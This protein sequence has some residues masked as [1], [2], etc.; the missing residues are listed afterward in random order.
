[1]LKNSPRSCIW[2]L[3][4]IAVFF[5]QRKIEVGEFG[6]EEDSATSVAEGS[7]SRLRKRSDI[8]P[9]IH[10]LNRRIDAYS[11]HD[12]RTLIE[13]IAIAGLAERDV[14]RACDARTKLSE[15]CD[16]PTADQFVREAACAGKEPLP[17]PERQI[18]KYVEGGGVTSV[19]RTVASFRFVIVV[20]LRAAIEQALIVGIDGKVKQARSQGREAWYCIMDGQDTARVL[21]AYGEL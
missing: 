1:M 20:V 17:I 19:T 10:R 12:V 8:Q 13:V 11:R 5:D 18:V 3:S 7:G 16:F 2:S 6:P 15:R 14:N 9:E 21:R 4:V